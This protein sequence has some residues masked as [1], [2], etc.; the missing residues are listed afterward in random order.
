MGEKRTV[1]VVTEISHGQ[2]YL[3]GVFTTEAAARKDYGAES[4]ETSVLF[5]VVPLFGGEV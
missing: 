2:H 4:A 3:Y 5:D 1:C